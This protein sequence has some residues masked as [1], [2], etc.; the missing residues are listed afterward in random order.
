MFSRHL[1]CSDWVTIESLDLPKG[2]LS[3]KYLYFGPR[4][5]FL[6]C[7]GDLLHEP[8]ECDMASESQL[9]VLGSS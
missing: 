8:V 2:V 5:M 3:P 4:A 1:N 6:R 9:K 7:R